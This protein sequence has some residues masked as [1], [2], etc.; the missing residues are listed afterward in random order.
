MAFCLHRS[1]SVLQFVL[2]S[3]AHS[4]SKKRKRKAGF[5]IRCVASI[6][7]LYHKSTETYI[8]LERDEPRTTARPTPDT[9]TVPEEIIN[10]E[11]QIVFE[12]EED[13]EWYSGIIKGISLF[14]P[15]CY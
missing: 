9:V 7:G 3:F 4:E 8:Q 5:K 15:A 2:H 6:Y 11:E 1:S 12:D 14:F 10:G 13:E